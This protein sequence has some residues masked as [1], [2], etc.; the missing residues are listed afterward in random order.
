MLVAKNHCKFRSRCLI[1]EFSFTDIFNDINH[2]YKTALFK[3]KNLWLL[4]FYMD[5]ASFFLF[6]KFYIVFV[7][8]M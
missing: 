3:K 6:Q 5:V 7:L 8:V 2:G 1:H 4:S